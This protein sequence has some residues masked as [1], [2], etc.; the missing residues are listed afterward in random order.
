MEIFNSRKSEKTLDLIKQ[1]QRR[2]ELAK[3][4]RHKGFIRKE[5]T[6]EEETGN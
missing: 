6:T 3:R 2:R 5:E 4:Q 1:I